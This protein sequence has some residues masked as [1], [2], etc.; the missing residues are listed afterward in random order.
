MKSG[1]NVHDNLN[2]I[3]DSLERRPEIDLLVLPEN[4]S[5][6]PVNKSEIGAEP[7]GQN[8]GSDYIKEFLSQLASEQNLFIIAGSLPLLSSGS[9]KPMA[10]CLIV[11]PQGIIGHYDKIHLFDVDVQT[12]RGPQRYCESDSYQ[13]GSADS[14]NLKV[15]KLRIGENDVRLGASICY[16]L[17]FPELYR[18][19]A[20]QEANIIT[21][22]AAFTYETGQAHWEFLLRARAVENQAF[23][24]AAAQVGDHAPKRSTWGHSMIVDPWGKVLAEKP[25]SVGLLYADL[26]LNQI[27]HL[28]QRFPVLE[29]RRL[30]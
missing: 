24:L 6:M 19:F 12:E 25:E 1:P 10:R 5:Q 16:D 11:S 28:Q 23:V 7:S 9:T 13:Q 18:Q 3:R 8:P 15:H 20:F 21:V 22:P 14:E 4:F 30:F 27:K 29:H 17:R 2:F 26:D